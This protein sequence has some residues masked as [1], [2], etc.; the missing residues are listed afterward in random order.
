M[1]ICPPLARRSHEVVRF[2]FLFLPQWCKAPSSHLRLAR[3][4]L[5]LLSSAEYEPTSGVKRPENWD[6]KVHVGRRSGPDAALFLP[7][8]LGKKIYGDNDLRALPLLRT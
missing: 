8:C 1:E 4:L 7:V 3:P 5:S 2:I 6:K